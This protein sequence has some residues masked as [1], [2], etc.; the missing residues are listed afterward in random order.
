VIALVALV[1]LAAPADES[2]YPAPLREFLSA[3]NKD[4]S[5]VLSEADKKSLAA[6]PD[7]TR[8]LLGAAADNVILGSAAH[9]KILLSLDLPPAAME[10]VAQDNCIL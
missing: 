2:K 6:L 5:L 1:L 9:L 8:N 10:I 4:G 7:H 3:K